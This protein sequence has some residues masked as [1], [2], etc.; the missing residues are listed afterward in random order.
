MKVIRNLLAG[1]LVCATCLLPFIAAAQNGAENAER[2]ELA[3]RVVIQS[4]VPG[5]M[6][7]LAMESVPPAADHLKRRNPDSD[8]EVIASAVAEITEEQR[9]MVVGLLLE[10]DLPVRYAH[11]F[12][13]EE[14]KTIATFA[15]TEAGQ[16]YFSAAPEI[17]FRAN[18][19]VFDSMTS[20]MPEFRK[21]VDQVLT[22][23]GLKF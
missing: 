18:R 8:S 15:E 14:L 3:K 16:R 22:A 19:Q 12:S 11:H 10:T 17:A 9:K 21:R 13:V 2:I 6:S 20:A 1:S 23:K 5:I 4:V 7:A